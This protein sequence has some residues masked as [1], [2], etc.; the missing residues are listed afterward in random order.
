VTGFIGMAIAFVAVVLTLVDGYQGSEWVVLAGLAFFGVTVWAVLVRP[1]VALSE[2]RLLL[3]SILSEVSLPLAGVEEVSIRQ[4]LVV[5]AGGKTWS[6][7]GLGRSRAELARLRKD[8]YDTAGNRADFVEARIRT[9]A[10]NARARSGV[11]LMSDEQFAMASGVR[12]A[13]SRPVI[14]ALVV[15]GITFLVGILT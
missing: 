14:A 11:L 7:T 15:L 13:W 4:F 10:E 2:D 8:G 1:A 12:R 3:R 5:R 6:S 9:R